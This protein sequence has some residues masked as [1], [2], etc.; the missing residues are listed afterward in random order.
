MDTVYDLANNFQRKCLE[1]VTDLLAFLKL[2]S[3]FSL[4]EGTSYSASEQREN[5][6]HLEFQ[7]NKDRVAIYIYL[8]EA[9]YAR[10]KDWYIWENPDYDSEDELIEAF[11]QSLRSYL[12]SGEP[13][14]GSACINILRLKKL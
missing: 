12:T 7:H 3:S 11:V 6:F 13:I 2:P 8:D 4:V 9:G 5:Y 1:K 14:E 10:N